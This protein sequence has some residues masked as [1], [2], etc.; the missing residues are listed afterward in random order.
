[1]SL[2]FNG[3]R[4]GF[5]HTARSGFG[6]LAF[7]ALAASLNG[8]V[9][10]DAP[11]NPLFP[12]V[13]HHPARAKRVL[14][15]CMEGAPSQVD[16]FDYKPKLQSDAGKPIG[17]G[18]LPSARLLPSPFAFKKRGQSGQWI[19]D[20][21]P[22]LSRHA[23]KL[24]VVRSMHTNLPNHP[25]AFVQL[26]TGLF[27]ATRP[28]LGAWVLYGL[29]CENENLPGFVSISPPNNNGSTTN[30]GSSFLPAVCQGLRLGSQGQPVNAAQV[31]NIR[32]N[33]FSKSDQSRQ[34]DLIRELNDKSR[35]TD[36]AS[37]LTDG[38]L[39]AMELGFRMQEDL[40][41]ALDVN[42]E[43]KTTKASYGVDT[44]ETDNFGRQCLMARR[45][46]ERGVRFVEVCQGGWDQHRNLREDHGRR[47]RSVDLPISGLLGD[48]AARGLLED[49]LVVWAGEFGRTPYSQFGLDGDG[50]DHN[51]KGFT[52]WMAGGGAKPGTSYGATDE[53]GREAVVDK[54][55][56][57]DL[58]ATILHLLGLDHMRLTHRHAG[59]EMRLT[60]TK[61]LVIDGI[62][63]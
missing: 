6:G 59:R 5:L 39:G 34:L 35:E 17:H 9:R 18:P 16:T 37:G 21:F 50:R 61:G 51:H 14:F 54:V 1:M 32:N 23:D 45:L 43:D 10:A 19:S 4:R 15:L 22:N 2:L 27:Q 30:Y 55:H 31:T 49:T 42:L 58:H 44:A 62:V 36:P 40:P 29:G 20:L 26:H 12:K 53:H 63:A 56:I 60:D 48:L 25:Q 47:A 52:I 8:R 41:R 24:C 3:S 57:H 33:R 11:N 46:L 28:S 13:G 38:L 7:G